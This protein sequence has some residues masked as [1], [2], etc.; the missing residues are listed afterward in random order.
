MATW[1]SREVIQYDFEDDEPEI[2]ILMYKCFISH[3]LFYIKKLVLFRLT[4][5]IR[6]SPHS[7]ICFKMITISRTHSLI[8][9]LQKE[10]LEK[11]KRFVLLHKMTCLFTG[12]A[13]D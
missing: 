10:F 6:I 11:K 9:S 3:S 5:V 13:A 1:L 4:F 7:S 2:F 12:Q 8:T